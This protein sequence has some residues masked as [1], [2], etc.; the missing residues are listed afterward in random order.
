MKEINGLLEGFNKVVTDSKDITT[1]IK[2][3][4]QIFSSYNLEYYT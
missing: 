4:K 2:V 1:Q 3:S